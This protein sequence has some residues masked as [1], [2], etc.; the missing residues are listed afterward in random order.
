MI[1]LGKTSQD[2]GILTSTVVEEISRNKIVE[3]FWN[4]MV[5]KFPNQY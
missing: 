4:G 3:S 5:D 2:L 1:K